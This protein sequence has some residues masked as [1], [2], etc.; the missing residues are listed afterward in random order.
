MSVGDSRGARPNTKLN[1]DSRSAVAAGVIFMANEISVSRFDQSGAEGL[2]ERIRSSVVSVLCW[3]SH[4][5]LV[6]GWYGV[7]RI[8]RTLRH[9]HTEVTTPMNSLPLSDIIISG[10]P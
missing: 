2:D 4:N 8:W 10:T 6:R 5:P 1:G 3:D 7:V 9:W